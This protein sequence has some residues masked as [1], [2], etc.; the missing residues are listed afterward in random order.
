MTSLLQRPRLVP[1]VDVYRRGD[2]TQ[3]GLDP[4]R[5]VLASDLPADVVSLLTSLD[6]RATTSDA[7]GRVPAP[8]RGDAV[9]LVD[10][11]TRR[12][13]V[14]DV[15]PPAAATVVVRGD[16]PVSAELACVLAAEGVGRVVVESAGPVRHD[17]VGLT[18][19][20]ADVGRSRRDVLARR[21]RAVNPSTC[22]RRLSSAESADLV[23]LTDVAG[24][25][26]VD[27]RSLMV[28]RQPHLPIRVR[29]G[30]AIVGPLVLPGRTG[31]L[32]CADLRRADLDDAWPALAAQLAGRRVSAGPVAARAAAGFGAG[33]VLRTL[34]RATDQPVIWDA[35]LELDV[36]TGVVVR[37]PWP[38]HPRC[39]YGASRR[40]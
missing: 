35:T 6:G 21:V 9:R 17:E 40:G 38:A 7:L 39:W 13:L 37:R 36:G 30:T 3:V 28:A 31:C 8:R 16:G 33:Q 25:D 14:E 4:G 26:P 23:V 22:T 29:D 10:E 32:H 5:A 2:R 1:G 34:R 18:F 12:G 19:A 27:A 20:P 11:L 15:R 24:V